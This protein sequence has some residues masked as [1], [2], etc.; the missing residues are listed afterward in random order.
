MINA[1]KQYEQSLKAD[2]GDIIEKSSQ[3]VSSEGSLEEVAQDLPVIRI[4]DTLLKHAILQE[5]SDIHIE[6]DEKRGSGA[7]PD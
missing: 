2:F 1:L 6:P 4:V 7:L 3:E 5:A